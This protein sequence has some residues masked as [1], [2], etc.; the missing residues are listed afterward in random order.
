MYEIIFQLHS[1]KKQISVGLI[2]Y[3]NVGKSSIINALKSKKVCNVAPVPGETKVSKQDFSFLHE[4]YFMG[5][6]QKRDPGKQ[7]SFFFFCDEGRGKHCFNKL[8]VP[9]LDSFLLLLS[10][11]ASITTFGI[12]SL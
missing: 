9:F 1:D 10:K 11:L 3:P 7:E 8:E 5:F 6:L 2:G 4:V 12:D